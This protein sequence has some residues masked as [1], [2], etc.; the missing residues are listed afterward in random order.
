MMDNVDRGMIFLFFSFSFR[1]VC[2]SCRIVC[3]QPSII[4][5]NEKKKNTGWRQHAVHVVSTSVKSLSTRF[6][7]VSCWLIY[8]SAAGESVSWHGGR[9]TRGHFGFVFE[10]QNEWGKKGDGE[11]KETVS[12]L[13]ISNFATR[14]FFFFFTY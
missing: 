1:R 10:V 8:L 11:K 6:T 13:K 12:K 4:F 14:P 9:K 5:F 3:G 2:I 7:L